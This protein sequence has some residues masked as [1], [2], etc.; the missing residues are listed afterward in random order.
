MRVE[1][2]TDGGRRAGF[3]RVGF[4]RPAAGLLACAA[5]VAA[6]VLAGGGCGGGSK[7]EPEVVQSTLQRD[8]PLMLRGTVGSFATVRGT[9]PVLVSGLG[10]VVGLNGTGGDLLPDAVAST[11]ERE[12]SLRGIGA[13][14]TQGVPGLEGKSPRELL[15]DKNTAVVLVQAAVAPGSPE[16]ATFD[17]AV[18][19]LNAT[20]LEGGILWTTD[21]RLGQPTTFGTVATRILAK[22]EGPIFINPFAADTGGDTE[23]Q[24]TAGRVLNGGRVTEPMGIE[25]VLDNESHTLAGSIVAA[26][27]SR[28]P[29]GPGDRRDTARGRSGD[30]IELRVPN[31]FR[32]EPET[33]LSL[34]QFLRVDQSAPEATSQA[35]V[36][37]MAANPAMADVLA[38]SLEGVGSK[39]LPFARRLYDSPETLTRLAALRAG[40]RLGDPLAADSL[41]DL[42]RNGSPSVQSDAIRLVARIDAGPR[43]DTGLRDLLT[44]PDMLVRIAAYEALAERAER[45]QVGRI[46]Q[47]QARAGD[48]TA[49]R[50]SPQHMRELARANLP[51]GT[52]QGVQRRLMP[53]GFFLDVVEGGTPMVYVTQ[54]RQPRVVVF[55][56]SLPIT[57]PLTMSAWNDRFMLVTEANEPAA[58][59]LLTP[60][61]GG[62]PVT[63]AAEARLVPLVELLSR[64][65]TRDEPRSGMSMSYSEVVGVL[66]ALQRA[67]G[68]AADFT[69]ES[70]RLRALLVAA[71]QSLETR[72]RP[73]TPKD[74]DIVVLS[75]NRATPVAPRDEKPVERQPRIV[76]IEPAAK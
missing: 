49:Q 4:A 50:L 63:A 65:G 23:V 19:A 5:V 57:R 18:R 15:R 24:R 12:M 45:A 20:S 35:L 73:E 21:L 56:G 51:S 64:R 47:W 2:D 71:E 36:E 67:G 27:N 29:A 25:I 62:R 48:P 6:T 38:W 16:D 76:P 32:D 55:G 58:R 31:R 40:A 74:R 10:L 33:F 39:A 26:I 9:E 3:A 52:I 69:T 13:S 22:A 53:G 70:D 60:A 14:E 61:S 66:Y 11:M 43:V 41:L 54:Q 1:L 8:V 75:R 59:V 37:A 42:A 46:A 72:E 68:L 17:V 34:I 44:N 30:S 28:F 7:R